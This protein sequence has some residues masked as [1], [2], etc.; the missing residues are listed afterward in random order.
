M[1]KRTIYD[2]FNP[3]HDS[4]V[5]CYHSRRMFYS[6]VNSLKKITLTRLC[7]FRQWYTEYL[8]IFSAVAATDVMAYNSRF[9]V[10]QWN[11]GGYLLKLNNAWQRVSEFVPATGDGW[12]MIRLFRCAFKM[13]WW[14]H[15][16]EA[17][18]ALLA[19]CAGNSPVTGEFSAQRPVTRNFDVYVDLRLNKRLSK[20]SWGWW[21]ETRS[22]SLWRH[23]NG[24]RRFI[25]TR[26][27]CTV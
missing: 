17:F 3:Q 12:A 2:T 20:Q 26:S 10:S 21:F 1:G 13:T 18:S 11:A 22:R 6:V 15:Q 19:L 9:N 25:P 27:P 23:C 14:R 16:M 24:S 8:V 7:S 4:T 5:F